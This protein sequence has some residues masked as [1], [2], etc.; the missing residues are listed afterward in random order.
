MA[1]DH[2]TIHVELLDEGTPT[3]RPV[4]AKR[5]ADGV[6]RIV[7]EDPDPEDEY[8]QFPS[9]SLVRCELRQ[10]SGG[11]CIVPVSLAGQAV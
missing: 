1:D 11:E 5:I 10:L 2:S 7:S 8:W 9:G 6:Y 4:K 3:W